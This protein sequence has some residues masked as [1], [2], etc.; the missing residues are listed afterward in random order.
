[1]HDLVTK[2]GT[3]YTTYT[4]NHYEWG[5]LYSIPFAACT[6]SSRLMKMARPAQREK[7][8]TAG[9]EERPPSMKVMVSEREVIRREGAAQARVWP[10]IS[11]TGACGPSE[12]ICCCIFNRKGKWRLCI[13]TAHLLCG[14]SYSAK[15]QR[16]RVS[17]WYSGKITR[18]I[19]GKAT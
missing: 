10:I 15:L 14:V 11:L 8:P 7:A 1:M 6:W 3:L 4:P 17:L 19:T 16:E 9:M 2:F 5:P 12:F 18:T 13:L